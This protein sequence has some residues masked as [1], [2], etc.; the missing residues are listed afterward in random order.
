MFK[1]N[2][3]RYLYERYL[4][5]RRILK[6]IDVLEGYWKVFVWKIIV[7]EE[8]IERKLCLRRILEGICVWGGYWKVFVWEVY[9]KVF[10]SEEYILK[11]I[12]WESRISKCIYMSEEDIVRFLCLKRILKGIYDWRWYLKGICMKSICIS[13][14]YWKVFIYFRRLMKCIY[15][16]GGYWKLF[17][18]EEDI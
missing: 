2:I 16:W 14:R 10:M 13:G 15:V 3:E 8:D 18:Y 5:Q 9:L 1:E 17:M 12:L 4:Y 11:G 6:D 7:S